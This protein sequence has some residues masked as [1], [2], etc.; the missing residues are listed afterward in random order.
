MISFHYKRNGKQWCKVQ[1]VIKPLRA[2]AEIIHDDETEYHSHKYTHI[3]ED[4]ILILTLVCVSVC[5][6]MGW[7]WEKE[8]NTDTELR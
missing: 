7:K 3:A 6:G 1:E 2:F 4:T 8:I 5:V